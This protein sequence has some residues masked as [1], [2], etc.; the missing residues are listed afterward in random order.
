MAVASDIAD[1]MRQLDTRRFELVLIDLAD[2]RGALAGIRMLRAV[3]PNLPLVGIVDPTSPATAAEALH[4]GVAEVLPWPFDEH[5]VV[6]TISN[7]RDRVAVDGRHMGLSGTGAGLFAQ[8]P[9]MRQVLDA[10]RGA[11]ATRRGLFIVGEPGTGRELV[12]R[13]IHDRSP[14]RAREFVSVDCGVPPTQLEERLFGTAAER[15]DDSRH[16]G[17][18]RL[19]ADS[20]VAR[21]DGGTLFLS[22]L[23]DAPARIQVRLSRVLR[24]REAHVDGR[25]ALTELDVRPI[26]A[27]DSEIDSAVEDGR[28][29]RELV[30][31][32]PLSRI[33]VPPLRGRRDDVPLLAVHFARVTCDKLGQ[34]AK[35]FSRA[36]LVVLSALPWNGNAHELRDLVETLMRAVTRPVVQIDDVLDHARLDGMST[37]I[38][39]GLTLRDAKARFERECISAVLLRHHGRVGEAAKALG[40]QRTNLYRKVRQ[41]NVARSLLSARR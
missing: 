2:D 40:I 30:D 41:L 5:D 7:V 32:F 17:T 28:L 25:G 3:N 27:V 18:E 35:G 10:V 24:D 33:E 12:A 4:A 19:S 16:V 20:A 34:P 39:Q 6:A 29:R 11:A 14:A 36:A 38:D 15:T 1:A 23:A 9:M 37:R 13:A 21:A 22:N 31:R 26:A 8:S